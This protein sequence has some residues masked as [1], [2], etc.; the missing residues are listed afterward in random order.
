MLEVLALTLFVSTNSAAR[1]LVTS[2]VILDVLD[3][4]LVSRPVIAAVLLV[5]LAVLE[6]TRVSKPAIALVFAVILEV[7][8]VILLLKP[9][10]TLVALVIS[11]SILLDNV[12]V[13]LKLKMVFAR[14]G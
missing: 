4:T 9:F 2:A 13:S 14:N 7:L 10:S 3:V 1:A 11:A 8:E 5:I 12:I 6:F